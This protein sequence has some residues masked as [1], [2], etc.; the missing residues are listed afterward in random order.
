MSH[1]NQVMG[2][3]FTEQRRPA[4]MGVLPLDQLVKVDFKRGL[5]SRP[6]LMQPFSVKGLTEEL[7]NRDK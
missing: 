2:I 4:A 7:H 3:M 5:L 6:D 1:N